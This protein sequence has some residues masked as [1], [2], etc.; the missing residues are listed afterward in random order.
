M[1]TLNI[2]Y[3]LSWTIWCADHDSY[4]DVQLFHSLLHCDFPSRWLQLLQWPLVSLAVTTWCAWP[5]RGESFRELMPFL[6][7]LVHSC[8]CCHIRHASP[9]WT[10][11][12][13]LISMGFIPSVLK[14]KDDRT[15]FFFGAY[16]KW[17][18][19]LYS[20]TAPLCCIP[21]SYCHLSATLQTM[22]II[23]VS[24]QDNRAVFW[25]SVTLLRFSFDSPSY[26]LLCVQC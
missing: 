18:R 15:L 23:V 25:I 5:C 22:S 19:H 3:F 9:Y 10:F 6:N 12:L 7:F 14:K 24:L 2:F 26:L 21:A 8:T 17:G 20:T 4:P 16:W 13:Q 1:K 11:I